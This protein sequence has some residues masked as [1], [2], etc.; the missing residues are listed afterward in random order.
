MMHTKIFSLHRLCCI[1][2][3]ARLAITRIDGRGSRRSWG[4]EGGGERKKD[5]RRS[6]RDAE[7]DADRKSV[8]V[9]EKD[10]EKERPKNKE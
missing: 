1:F 5:F 3:A 6:G 7:R 8:C 2:V 4:R 10:R 9:C